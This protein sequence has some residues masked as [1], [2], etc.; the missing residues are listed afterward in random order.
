MRHI[1]A[2]LC[3]FCAICCFVATFA[4]AISPDPLAGM[5]TAILG[6][7]LIAVAFAAERDVDVEP[8]RPSEWE[9]QLAEAA[10]TRRKDR[11]GV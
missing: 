8:Y 10:R 11:S 2:G 5:F 7:L 1:G 6:A 4:L 9:E 3:V